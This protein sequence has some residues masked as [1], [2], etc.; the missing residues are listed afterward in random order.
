MTFFVSHNI[1]SRFTLSIVR[2]LINWPIVTAGCVAFPIFVRQQPYKIVLTTSSND[3]GTDSSSEPCS[4][5]PSKERDEEDFSFRSRFMNL[6]NATASQSKLESSDVALPRI[7]T[8]SG[9]R[10]HSI[11]LLVC[12]ECRKMH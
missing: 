12:T 4:N 8:F 10:T 5:F 3:E 2:R 9:K 7:S 11:A 1:S 6:K